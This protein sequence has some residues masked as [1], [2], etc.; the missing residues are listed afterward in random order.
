MIFNF[1]IPKPKFKFFEKKNIKKI[2]KN[3]ITKIWKR[4]NTYH[5]VHLNPGPILGAFSIY[6][7][8]SSFFWL[9]F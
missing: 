3:N 7:F 8:F 9:Y 4:R 6:C 1:N 5:Y 2:N